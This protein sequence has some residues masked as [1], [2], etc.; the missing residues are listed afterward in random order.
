[1]AF[2]FLY[3]WWHSFDKGQMT[4]APRKDIPCEEEEEE[5]EEFC[6][7]LGEMLLFYCLAVVV[8]KLGSLGARRVRAGHPLSFVI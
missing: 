8:L 4:P 1:M 3:N 5:D 2:P 7:F 6:W